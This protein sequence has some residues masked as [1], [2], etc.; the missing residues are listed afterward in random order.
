MAESGIVKKDIVLSKESVLHP[1][2]IIDKSKNSMS[3]IKQNDIGVYDLARD[4]FLI[5][6][7][8]Y[9][10]IKKNLE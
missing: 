10:K 9:E 3:S 8:S 7:N 4:S 5:D 1:M 2:M 6:E